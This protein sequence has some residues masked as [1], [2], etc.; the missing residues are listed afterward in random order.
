MTDDNSEEKNELSRIQTEYLRRDSAGLNRGF[1]YTNPAFVY[2]IQ[3]REWAILSLLRKEGIN[4][5][6]LEVLEVGCGTGHILERFREFGARKVI[7]IDLMEHRIR[8][9]ATQYSGVL[10]TVGSGTALPYPDGSFNL[11]TQFMCLSSILDQNTRSLVAKEMLRVLKPGGII[12]SY[13]MRTTPA[14]MRLLST[15]RS[16]PGI[17]PTRPLDPKELQDL[18]GDGRMIIKTIS[19]NFKLAAIADKSHFLAFIIGLFPWLRTHYLV[20]IHKQP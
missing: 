13:D 3:E 12:L 10:L 14:F 6:N 20:L 2:H 15:F 9:G 17:T 16:Q 7:G 4:I 18:F 1:S 5:D 11:V 8:A 19:L